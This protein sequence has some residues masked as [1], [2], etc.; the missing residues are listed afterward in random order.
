MNLANLYGSQTD[1]YYIYTPAWRTNSAGIRA[2]HYLCHSLN[3]I[4]QKA[5]LVI[6]AS[7]K[8]TNLVNANLN[9]PILTKEMVREHKR[10][11][12]D[13]IVIY[14][15]TVPGNPLN[16]TNTVRYLMNYVGLLGGQRKFSENE[17]LLAFSQNI[18]TDYFNKNGK[19]VHSVLFLPPSD[20]RE[21]EVNRNKNQ[22]RK[23]FYLLYAAKYRNFVGNHPQLPNIPMIEIKRDS[24][25]AQ[26]R[27][28]LIE[29]LGQ[30]RGV[31]AF[32]NSAIISEAVLSGVPGYFIE[33]EF[34]EQAIAEAE[35]GWDGMGWG[36]TS[37]IELQA[38]NT[39]ENGIE[40]YLDS[41]SK[42]FESLSI[43][44]N[45]TQSREE[46]LP[47]T[48]I[49]LPEGKFGLMLHRFR[50]A[51]QIF[52][53]LGFRRLLTVCR[54]YFLKNLRTKSPDNSTF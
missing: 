8:S 22:H 25:F 2:L 1:P 37:E 16:S 26:T 14:S 6:P 23:D 18:A 42:Y 10:Y 49:K 31:I 13:P 15:E 24:K 34:L 46:N 28:E 12:L 33:N 47:P 40:R 45:L 5:F 9:T 48:E 27:S 29:L 7:Y 4:G 52:Q 50:L 20:P 43:F 44:V 19:E 30:C 51:K 41:V 32:E 3:S 53:N 38:H 54:A 36:F 21:F 35:L 39:L 11:N 17:F